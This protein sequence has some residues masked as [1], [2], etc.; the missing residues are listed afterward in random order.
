L[1]P[2]GGRS[3]LPPGPTPAMPAVGPCV[4]FPVDGAASP[5]NPALG[6]LG[7]LGVLGSVS[8]LIVELGDRVI[9]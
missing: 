8:V 5:P 9:G 1:L 6:V 3:L 2:R 4:S 7:V